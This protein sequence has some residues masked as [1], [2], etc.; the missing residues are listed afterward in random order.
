MVYGNC[1]KRVLNFLCSKSEVELMKWVSQRLVIN[2]PVLRFPQRPNYENWK[3]LL[4]T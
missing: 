2:I 1:I 4:Q 3:G